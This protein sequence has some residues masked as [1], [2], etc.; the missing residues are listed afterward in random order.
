[1][2]MSD[3]FKRIL[4]TILRVKPKIL[5]AEEKEKM[6]RKLTEVN[7]T[8]DRDLTTCDKELIEGLKMEEVKLS[9]CSGWF[10]SR[11]GN[12]EDRIV[13]YIHGGG[14]VNSYTRDRM[15]FVSYL[16]KKFGY[17]VQSLNRKAFA[18]LT[19]EDLKIGEHRELTLE[20]ENR[21]KSL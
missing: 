8:H 13:Y 16:V 4:V 18:F 7:R 14:F 9:N 1:M 17:N 21:L 6:K 15:R 11:E 19:V 5:S 12:P 2:R 3:V 20:E 10:I